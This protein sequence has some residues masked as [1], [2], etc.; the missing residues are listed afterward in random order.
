MAAVEA[1]TEQLYSPAGTKKADR[2]KAANLVI[3]E[4]SPESVA[5]AWGACL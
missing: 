2:Q 3:I 1:A 5:H 4:L